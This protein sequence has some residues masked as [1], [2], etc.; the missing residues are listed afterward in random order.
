MHYRLNLSDS[1]IAS[2]SYYYVMPNDVIVV[3]PLNAIS[4]SYSNITYT[5]LLSTISTAIAVL[6]FA[7]LR[8]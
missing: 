2:K 8:F 4:S 5:T 3:E 6:L 7:G 1:K